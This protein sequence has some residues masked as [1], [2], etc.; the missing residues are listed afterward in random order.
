MAVDGPTPAGSKVAGDPQAAADAGQNVGA[1]TPAAAAGFW[2]RHGPKIITGVSALVGGFAGMGVGRGAA[3]VVS[4]VV[5]FVVLGGGAHAVQRLERDGVIQRDGMKVSVDWDRMPRGFEAIRDLFWN[6]VVA[7][8]GAVVDTVRAAAAGVSDI[9]QLNSESPSIGTLALL[10]K[11]VQSAA[12]GHPPVKAS[13]KGVFSALP[14]E[15]TAT[16]LV[17][18]NNNAVPPSVATLVEGENKGVSIVWGPDAAEGD[19]VTFKLAYTEP[20]ADGAGA[21]ETEISFPIERAPIGPLGA[22]RE[23]K[24]MAAS[25]NKLAREVLA[26]VQKPEADI[27][28]AANILVGRVTLVADA[29][30]EEHPLREGLLAAAKTLSTALGASDDTA[31]ARAFEGALMALGAFG[32]FASNKPYQPSAELQAGDVEACRPAQKL[33]VPLA[34]LARPD[35]AQCAAALENLSQTAAHPSVQRFAK[36]L[37][38]ARSLDPVGKVLLLNRYLTDRAGPLPAEAPS[39]NAQQADAGGNPDWLKAAAT[40]LGL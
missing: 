23:A 32:Q 19:Q 31:L 8:S 26:M 27:E 2:Q 15:V 34:E 12:N 7:A 6:D 10:N 4:A 20:S 1:G 33:L 16:K 21:T 3:S 18:A 13:G 36:A 24:A 29:L 39:A 30:P 11:Y 14:S 22:D 38:G 28:H 25:A 9:I 17:D 40:V 35:P 37:L 5:G